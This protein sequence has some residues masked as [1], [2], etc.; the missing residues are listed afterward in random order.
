MHGSRGKR[1]D[2]LVMWLEYSTPGGLRVSMEE[3]LRGVLDNFPEDITETSE[4]PAAS[5]LFIVWEDREQELLNDKRDQAFHSAVAQLLFTGI[6]CR[7]DA[8]TA[9]AF[10]MTRVRKPDKD[11]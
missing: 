2:Y 4:T 5:N 6:R 3:Y 10:L 11:D 7:K 8:H 1:H 9:I